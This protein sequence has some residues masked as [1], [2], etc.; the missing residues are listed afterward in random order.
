MKDDKLCSI[1]YFFNTQAC[2]RSAQDKTQVETGAQPKPKYYSQH[3][4]YSFWSR[5]HRQG[6][7]GILC[8][9]VFD[10]KDLGTENHLPSG[11]VDTHFVLRVA[12]MHSWLQHPERVTGVT[13]VRAN[14]ISDEE[15]DIVR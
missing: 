4:N 3:E 9:Q 11:R 8:V 6:L 13:V 14:S 5:S 12:Q 10:A 15:I 7:G 1:V 2:F